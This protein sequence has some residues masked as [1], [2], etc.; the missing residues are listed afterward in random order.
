MA[1]VAA[2]SGPMLAHLGAQA[3]QA[4]ADQSLGP[5][6][7]TVAFD[8]SALSVG[9]RLSGGQKVNIDSLSIG[10]EGLSGRLFVEDLAAHPLSMSLFDGFDVALTDF[11]ITLANGGLAASHI[12]GRLTIPFFTDENGEPKTVAIEFGYK[13]DGTV[14]ISL[15]A[16]DDSNP[17][18]ADGLV[19]LEYKIG[20]LVTI[21]LDLASLEVDT[22]PDGTWR[23]LLS[24]NLGIS[25]E[26]MSWPGFELRGLGIDSKG[27]VTVD[28]GWIN[29]PHQM[30]LDFHGFHVALEKIGFG[31]DGSG[32]WIGFSGDIYLV[33]GMKL[34]GSVRGLRINLDTGALSFDG[35]GIAF[36][37]PD[38]L[39]FEGEIDHIHVDAKKP[40]DLAA[41]GLLPS[42]YDHIDGPANDK[43]VDVFAGQIKL[44][45]VSIKL[46]VDAN[47][48]VGHFG[49][50]SVFFL[51]VEADLPVGIPI[52]TDVSLYGLR[53]LVA[54]GLQPDPAADGKTWWEW[55][56]Y[57]PGY[58]DPPEYSASDFKKWMVPH[59][60]A[61]AIGAGGTIGTSA[62]DGFTV[63]AAITLVVMV[64]GPVISL[65]GKAN[66]LSKRIG[67]AAQEA[68]FEAMA[69]F[70]GNADTFDLTIDAQ[71]QIP[72]V[73]DIEGTAELFVDAPQGQWFFA[74]GKPPH[75]KRIK[76]R[77]FD[78]FESDAY[79][80]VSQHGLVTGTW[81]G[82]SGHWS[83]GPLSV[84][85]E[86]YLAT[87]AAIQWSP[88]QI[89]GGVELHGD[90]HLSAFGIGVGLTADA[91]L[92]GCAPDPF[93]VHGE[94]SVELELPWP[95]PDVGATI[96][97]TWGGD[98][99]S[100]PP[101][102]LALSHVDVTL[103]DHADAADKASSDRYVLLAHRPEGPRPDT[104]IQYDDP[105][106][107]GILVNHAAPANDPPIDLTP[108]H[109]APVVPQDAHFTL[110]FAHPTVDLA[111][112]REAQ[113]GLPADYVTVK[114]PSI[115]DAD[116]MSN[117][118][119][120]PPAPQW[121]FRHSLKAVTLYQ[122]NASAWNKVCSFPPP[123]NDSPPIGVTQ[124][125]GV[126]LAQAKADQ[127]QTQLKVFTWRLLPGQ[128]WSALWDAGSVPK[129]RTGDFDDQNLHF[130][131]GKHSAEIAAPPAFGSPL[132][133]G[134]QFEGQTSPKKF[135]VVVRFPFKVQISSIMSA[136]R[137]ADK[138]FVNVYAPDWH[139]D[140][141]PLTAAS[142][143]QS[144]NGVWTQT[145]ATN[146]PLISELEVAPSGSLL[147]YAINYSSPNIPMAIL[148][149]PHTL[150]ALKTE[151]KIEAGRANGASLPAYQAVPGGDPIVEFTY[152]QTGAGPGTSVI[153]LAGLNS[154]PKPVKEAPYQQL[155]GSLDKLQQP[156]ASFPLAGALEDLGTYTEWS[157]PQDGASAAYY[158]YDVNVEFE[159]TYVNALYTAFSSGAV[160]DS[161]HFR[162]VDRNQNH[163]LLVPNAIHV[164]SI[165]ME[166][167]LVAGEIAV[168]LPQPIAEKP[169]V[170]GR[171]IDFP[172][173]VNAGVTMLPSSSREQPMTVRKLQGAAASSPH[174]R[175][176]ELLEK[177]ASVAGNID[178]IPS[179]D[180]LLAPPAA[181]E[182]KVRIQD[183]YGKNAEL[184]IP[185]IDPVLAAWW[186]KQLK[187]A[188]DAA[189]ARALWFKPLLPL[190]RYTLDV[191][192]GPCNRSSGVWK[193]A[194]GEAG[195][196]LFAIFTAPDAT[197]V[198]A[199]LKAYLAYEDALTTLQRVQFTTSRYATFSAQMK[200]VANQLGSG[201]ATAPI[202]HYMTAIEPAAWLGNAAN[203][204]NRPTAE[205]TYND[206]V[207]ALDTL[208][209]N[210]DPLADERQKDGKSQY[211]IAAL[212]EERKA[213]ADTW[214]IFYDA[215]A[216]SFDGLI[217]AL[218]RPD[219]VSTAKPV[220]VPDTELTLFTTPNGTYVRALL[221]E[222]PEPLPWRRIRKSIYL[223]PNG[224]ASGLQDIVVLWNGDGTRGLIVARGNAHGS[225]ALNIVFQ[226]N[227]GAQAP[228]ITRNSKA[229]VDSVN[230]G[231]LSLGVSRQIGPV[232][233]ETII[234]NEILA[235]E[236]L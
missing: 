110:S 43:K 39:T 188:Q 205:L 154:P 3:L 51:D 193:P 82:Y 26:G 98:D 199:A 145:F 208:V 87:L 33:E 37:I 117:L 118:N 100:I 91:L 31:Q 8:N 69:T 175:A 50:Q 211:G 106:R 201:P 233:D 29:L 45:I 197:G 140:G 120:T 169:K 129:K 9:V 217:A 235:R 149:Q 189:A 109:M 225:Y 20:S 159:E 42:I 194:E 172:V 14:S 165:P 74:L 158:G 176:I 63:S 21:D 48:I 15:A 174:S 173:T 12:G 122:W 57:S 32:R 58:L 150:Y 22:A 215:T 67:S 72:V 179:F 157:W 182:A 95:L 62:D 161:L 73:L 23:I 107:S 115:V 190:T 102:P 81:T 184:L 137:V 153:T 204:G 171:I 210:F 1:N 220:A 61:F 139:G 181:N 54:T 97:L 155:V 55:Y 203:D 136:D 64:P 134:L 163:T 234:R 60:G 108:I 147:L 123:S 177:R 126:W 212:V 124:L 186:L 89:A 6:V 30:A 167:A 119:P 113:G 78:L 75:D 192:A 164:P 13:S 133:I 226:G 200:N 65:I 28:G 135:A 38:V 138:E 180:Q 146:S 88:L 77:I 10:D 53:G 131:L 76:A 121:A 228:C 46:E 27:H 156:A 148:P 84:S 196:T 229:V 40:E 18:T 178:V 185:Q 231:S 207:T 166:S 232:F 127:V 68:N 216:R 227:I 114:L 195:G 128:Q 206:A 105:N 52:F 223:T 36:E 25:V 187:E 143:T 112:F 80:V 4:A 111:G 2:L 56:K 86:A 162:C 79:F 11:D 90:V 94:I 103:G 132:P 34:G 141:K 83:F 151:T 198:L 202:R 59:A 99:G 19:N 101:A 7:L 16:V 219:L 85:L 66:I 104:L 130:Q 142:E 5:G 222:S 183:L 47:F 218:G 70:D 44:N 41:V 214:Q 168:P 116:D 125:D 24:G 230:L 35:V 236:G 71:Y 221:I 170:P 224:G 49:G 213:T 209:A 144:A 17:I 93:W 191:V 152:F 160:A 96:S 92:E